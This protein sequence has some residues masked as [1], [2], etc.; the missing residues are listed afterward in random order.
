MILRHWGTDWLITYPWG[1]DRYQYGIWFCHPNRGR[2]A[3]IIIVYI[4]S[5]LK[6]I[7][8][9]RGSLKDQNVFHNFI[10]GWV[11][12]NY[13]EFSK[14]VAVQFLHL[15]HFGECSLSHVK[16]SKNPGISFIALWTTHLTVPYP[17]TPHDC[18]LVKPARNDCSNATRGYSLLAL[19]L[20][21]V[22]TSRTTGQSKN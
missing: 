21:Q 15:Q 17:T 2:A 12:D 14:R 5:I 1:S 18:W 16:L 13:L 6:D 3:A 19:A 10:G 4:C 22:K 7:F 8:E 11:L 20:V 9:C